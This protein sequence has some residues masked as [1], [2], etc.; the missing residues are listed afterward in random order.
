MKVVEVQTSILVVPN[1]PPWSTY[2]PVN[3]YI[4][5]RILTDEGLEGLGYTVTVGPAGAEAI[6]AE[7]ESRLIPALIGRDPLQI[8]A[9]WQEMYHLDRGL[10]KKG[11]TV[12][13]MSALDIGLWD[14][15]GKAA[16][17]PI[18]QLLGGSPTPIPA[19]GSGGFIGYSVDTI[20]GEAQSLIELGCRSYKLKIG[21]P[22]LAENVER[23]R[24]VR[25][26]LGPEIKLMVDAN[27][28]WDMLTSIQV[29]RRLEPYDIFWYEEPVLADHIE[30]CAQ[31]AQALTIPIAT[32][33]N[34]YTR[35]GFRDLIEKRAAYYLNP[36]IHRCGGI[37]ETLRIC[38][39]AAAHDLPIAPHLAPELS[40]QVLAAIPNAC[41][42]EWPSGQPDGLWEHP[43]VVIDGALTPPDRP[44]H[45]MELTAEALTR[46]RR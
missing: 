18:W 11:V 45:G 31:V 39:L 30:Q 7:L 32:G 33:E 40:V 37:G 34:E 46:Y 13:A 10:R 24:L 22:D 17:R 3:A 29:G 25:E 12:Y 4:V 15:L 20:V 8:N 9:F 28:R 2:Y 27:Q 42:L 19:Y 43:P 44:G 23:V 14:L 5:A 16:S 36:D 35:Y 38:H 21:L 26:A 6:R 1:A 41:I